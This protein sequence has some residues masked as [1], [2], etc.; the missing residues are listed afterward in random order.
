MIGK[1]NHIAIAVPDL[2]SASEIYKNILGASVSDPVPMP[3]HG[4]TTVFVELPNTK[5]ELLE[6]LG[7]DSPIQNYLLK[8][9]KAECIT[10]AMRLMIYMHQGINWLK[11]VQP[12][13]EVVIPP[14]GHTISLFYF[15]IQKI[16]V[17]H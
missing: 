17:E 16:F 5:I 10:S 15:S 11:M 6:P 8:T 7:D 2:I 13:W 4:V 14:L 12:Y 9:P 1:L 3:D